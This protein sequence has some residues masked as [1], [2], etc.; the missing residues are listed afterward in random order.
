MPDQTNRQKAQAI[1]CRIK[2]LGVSGAEIARGL[3]ISR[4]RLHQME[5]LA[6][7]VTDETVD[8]L[9]AI[10]QRALHNLCE[11][12]LWFCSPDPG[13]DEGNLEAQRALLDA[14]LPVL[15]DLAQKLMAAAQVDQHERVRQAEIALAIAKGQV[16]IPE[17]S[18]GWGDPSKRVVEPEAGED[19]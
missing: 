18:A 1:I 14:T 19:S 13:T 11:N 15:V 2:S 17:G 3:D 7:T 12:T 9:L 4:Q 6:A 5:N 10:H 8:G 16:T